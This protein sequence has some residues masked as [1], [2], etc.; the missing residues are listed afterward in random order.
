MRPIID[1]HWPNQ[2]EGQG[3]HV[4]HNLFWLNRLVMPKYANRGD[5]NSHILHLMHQ[6]A[7]INQYQP[8]HW[9]VKVQ[10]P[11]NNSPLTSNRQVVKII[12]QSFIL[13]T[14]QLRRS[15]Y[16]TWIRLIR[17]DK[18]CI[19]G[20]KELRVRPIFD[21]HWPNQTGRRSKSSCIT[22]QCFG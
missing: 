4:L 1:P 12:K 3:C 10:G 14:E 20:I 16:E 21:P 11:C 2:V 8:N 19:Q 5:M 9:L 17:S 6:T 18:C 15:C 13:K 7:M 22:T